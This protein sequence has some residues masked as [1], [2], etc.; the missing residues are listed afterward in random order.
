MKKILVIT[1]KESDFS[2]LLQRTFSNVTILPPE[3]ERFCPADFDALCILGGNQEEPLLLSP[4]LRVCVEEMRAMKKPVFSEF[5]RSIAYSYLENVVHTTH[6]RLVYCGKVMQIPGLREGD[7]L[8]THC[9]DCIHYS[10]RNKQTHPVLA[11]HN[12]V[13]AHS[14]IQMQ[15]DEHKS[16]VWGL[17]CLDESTLICSFRL[18]NF[19][20]AR[21]APRRAFEAVISAVFSFLAGER[22]CVPFEA[23]VCTYRN[24]FTANTSAQPVYSRNMLIFIERHN[25]AATPHLSA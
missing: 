7:V 20:R 14:N 24:L 15:E 6:H 8:D 19:R 13:C 5:V 22:I 17:W 11:L 21:L 23:P 10:F 25:T 18:C 16:G 1:G 12:Y 9:N 3:T 2:H 4:S